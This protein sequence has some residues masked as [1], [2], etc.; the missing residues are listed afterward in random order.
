LVAQPGLESASAGST[1]ASGA[2][3][4]LYITVERNTFHQQIK[5]AMP[6][7][8]SHSENRKTGFGTGNRLS[9]L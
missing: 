4:R 2:T 3:P 6:N 1:P 7:R 9:T 5:V 8:G